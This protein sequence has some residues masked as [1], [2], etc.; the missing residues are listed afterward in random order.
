MYK[1]SGGTIR[2]NLSIA[3]LI[4]IAIIVI[5]VYLKYKRYDNRDLK[6]RYISQGKVKMITRLKT[7]YE[8]YPQYEK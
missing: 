8:F 5:G 4:Q 1:V 3:L 7:N 2:M 6:G